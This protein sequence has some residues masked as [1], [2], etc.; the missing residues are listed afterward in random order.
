LPDINEWGY[1]DLRRRRENVM[2]EDD[3]RLWTAG[4]AVDGYAA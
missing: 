3:I 4:I 1:Q 2:T